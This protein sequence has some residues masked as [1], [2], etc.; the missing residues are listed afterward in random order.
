M[1]TA[2]QSAKLSAES[3]SPVLIYGET[4]TGKELFAQSIHNRSPRKHKP[5]L[6]INCASIPEN[7]LEGLL[8]GTSKGAFT[9]AIDKAGLLEKAAGGTVLLDEINSM[10]L[11]LQ[12]MMNYKMRRLKIDRKK[13]G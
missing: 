4:G 9:D 6:A 8:F 10:P 7:L 13:Y 12:E 5:F 1:L 2:I 11:S 3:A